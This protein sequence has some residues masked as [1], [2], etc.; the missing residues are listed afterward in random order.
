MPIS[1][2]CLMLEHDKCDKGYCLCDCHFDFKETSK[3][4]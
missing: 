3:Y 2:K 4:K 1:L